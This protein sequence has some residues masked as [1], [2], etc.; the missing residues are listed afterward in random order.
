MMT[1]SANNGGRDRPASPLVSTNGGFRWH[2]EWIN[3]SHL[4]GGEYVGLEEV[5]ADVWAVYFEP[6][7][8]GC[9]HV[10]KGVI[11]CLD[12]SSSRNPRLPPIRG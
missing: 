7:S 6:V 12:G 3:V 8:L 10:R 2:S 11:I 1:R 5:A 9:M 4:F